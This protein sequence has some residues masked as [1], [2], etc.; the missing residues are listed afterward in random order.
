LI[1]H[2]LVPLDGS[3]YAEIALPYAVELANAAKAHLHL[4]KAVEPGST[5][6]EF[7]AAAYLEKTAEGLYSRFPDELQGVTTRVLYGRPAGEVLRYAEAVDADITVIANRG[8][9]NDPKWFLG[10]VAEKI[11][12][13]GK[14]SVLIVKKPQISKGKRK[15]RLI[16]RILLPLDG[17]EAGEAAIP[18][19]KELA[20]IMKFKLT[21]LGVV[22]QAAARDAALGNLQGEVPPELAMQAEAGEHARKKAAVA[23]LRKIEAA[24]KEEKIPSS[25]ITVFGDPAEQ[26]LDYA[27]VN[28]IDL[29][30]LSTHGRSGP[31]RWAFGSITDKLLRVE[32]APVLVVK[33]G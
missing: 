3:K 23:Y 27:A 20:G 24:L 1:N 7:A 6:A 2:I 18:A 15:K 33:A 8:E 10:A 12:R 5:S 16:K 26:I 13:A 29:I 25:S 28:N 31:G 4:A 11:L 14:K 19:V 21:L 22:R 17:S 32:S 30:A 9:T